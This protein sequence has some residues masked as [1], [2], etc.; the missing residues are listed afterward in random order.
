ML[1]ITVK[2]KPDTTDAFCWREDVELACR[3]ALSFT[4]DLPDSTGGALY[5]LCDGVLGSPIFH[6]IDRYD[7]PGCTTDLETTVID[8]VPYG[9]KPAHVYTDQT[10][11]SFSNTLALCEHIQLLATRHAD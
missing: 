2:V 9:C 1:I 10:I 4:V 8:N 6:L 5:V 7:L 3:L 11:H